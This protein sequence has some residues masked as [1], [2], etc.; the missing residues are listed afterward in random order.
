MS[1]IEYPADLLTKPL[2]GDTTTILEMMWSSGR[3]ACNI[4]VLEN[5]RKEL[6]EEM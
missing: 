1:G 5:Y 3:L 6:H 4:N 2:S